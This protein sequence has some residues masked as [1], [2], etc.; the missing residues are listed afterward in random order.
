MAT[1]R[2]TEKVSKTEGKAGVKSLRHVQNMEAAKC[3][4]KIYC[5]KPIKDHFKRSPL[6]SCILVHFPFQRVR[7]KTAIG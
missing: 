4:L 6:F 5:Q 3:L 7:M 1:Y 2:A